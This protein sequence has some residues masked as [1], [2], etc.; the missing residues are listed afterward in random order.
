MADLEKAPEITAGRFDPFA[1][2]DRLREQLAAFPHRSPLGW[3][4]P[5][6]GGFVPAADVEETDDSWII[7]VELP[8]VDKKDIEVE[9]HGHRV[10]IT[11][12]RKEK[13]RKGI[14]RQKK[15]VTGS[16]RYEVVLPGDFAEERV[17][18]AL[19]NGELIVRLPKP[20]ADRPRKI[21]VN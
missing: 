9:V 21:A 15:R 13:V 5:F 4:E 10:V 19:E 8:G 11:G 1:E 2:L 6:E 7:E 12:E 20:E 3:L 18:A 16:F 17:E 14:L